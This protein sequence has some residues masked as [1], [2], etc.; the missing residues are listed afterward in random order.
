MFQQ[1]AVLVENQLGRFIGILAFDVSRMTLR[2]A[3]DYA[4]GTTTTVVEELDAFQ[5]NDM[6]K[7]GGCA[8]FTFTVNTHSNDRY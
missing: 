7:R 6:V 1:R 2:N 4:W 8:L 5:L 3:I